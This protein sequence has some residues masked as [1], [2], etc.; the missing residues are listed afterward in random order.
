[1]A[2]SRHRDR[3]V[4]RRNAIKVL[5][6]GCGLVPM[7]RATGQQKTE[8]DS[9]WG[10]D[11]RGK[12]IYVPCGEA[13]AIADPEWIVI[14]LDDLSGFK[15]TKDGKTIEIPSHEIWEALGGG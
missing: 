5:V 9:C 12:E 14:A 1:M 13:R 4:N 3:A 15:V 7:L 11:E 10:K 2:E 8:R 6:A